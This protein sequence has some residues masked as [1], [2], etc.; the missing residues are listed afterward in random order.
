MNDPRIR[1]T[2]DHVL[3]AAER[4][5]TSGAPQPITYTSL[6][7]ESTVSRRT[8]YIHWPTIDAIFA[9]ILARRLAER[10]D[11][12]TDK[13]LVEKLTKFLHSLRAGLNDPLE[14]TALL[15]V[16]QDASRGEDADVRLRDITA[17]RLL[18]FRTRVGS[19]SPENF[20]LLVGPLFMTAL[21]LRQPITD[22]LLTEQV[23]FGLSIMA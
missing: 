18:L 3:A 13:S 6:A 9:D 7:R 12:L 14:S 10:F 19:I 1:R 11:E 22:R 21:I 8:I 23:A 2:K 4:L 17:E 20:S 16:M 5:M 15:T